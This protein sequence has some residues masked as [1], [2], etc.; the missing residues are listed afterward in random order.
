MP[1]VSNVRVKPNQHPYEKEVN[2]K[3]MSQEEILSQKLVAAIERQAALDDKYATEV[4]RNEALSE[5]IRELEAK[6]SAKKKF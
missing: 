3:L 5:R 4:H 6:L 1:D 2:G